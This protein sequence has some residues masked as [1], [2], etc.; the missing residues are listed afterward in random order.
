MATARSPPSAAS[1][2][3]R[4]AYRCGGSPA[5]WFRAATASTSCAIQKHPIPSRAHRPRSETIRQLGYW[6]FYGRELFFPFTPQSPRVCEPCLGH[7]RGLCRA[8]PRGGVSSCHPLASPRVPRLARC[9]RRRGVSR[10]TPV[11]HSLAVSVGVATLF[12]RRRRGWRCA[13]PR[14]RCRFSRS[15]SRDC[16]VPE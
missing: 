2:C 6:Y 12:H 14:V 7:R 11:E 1:V 9:H 10:W 16:S 5:S 3:S 13:A 4:S 15:G 8:D